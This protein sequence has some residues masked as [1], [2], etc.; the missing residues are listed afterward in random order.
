MGNREEW[1]ILT[2]EPSGQRK[3][4]DIG[5]NEDGDSKMTPG[6]KAWMRGKLG[7]Y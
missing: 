3:W 7:Y 4:L 6:F 5:D 2:G 1:E